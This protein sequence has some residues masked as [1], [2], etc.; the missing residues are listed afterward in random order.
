[1]EIKIENDDLCPAGHGAHK[2]VQV[3][4]TR[5][6]NGRTYEILQCEKCDDVSTAW[7]ERD[8]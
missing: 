6:E 7:E 3:V 2:W 8:A 4:K 1:M 5:A